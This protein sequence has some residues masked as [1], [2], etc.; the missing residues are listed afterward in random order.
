MVEDGGQAVVSRHVV[1]VTEVAGCF[2]NDDPSSVLSP[3]T[4]P[5]IIFVD[6]L[7][8]TL[9][10]VMRHLNFSRTL[11]LNSNELSSNQDYFRNWFIL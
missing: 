2:W 4:Q 5:S 8:I 10:T 11:A 6:K 3:R 1:A 9:T 7:Y